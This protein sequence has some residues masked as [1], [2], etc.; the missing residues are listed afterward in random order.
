MEGDPRKP[1][2]WPSS[3]KVTYSVI[4]AVCVPITSA[5]REIPREYLSEVP[6]AL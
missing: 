3:F 1:F 2:S 6:I 5:G 4:F